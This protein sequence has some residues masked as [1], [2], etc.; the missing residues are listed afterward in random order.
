MLALLK[1]TLLGEM[2][3]R[4]N[5]GLEVL[6]RLWTIFS[7]PFSWSLQILSHR[8]LKK[9]LRL[10]SLTYTRCSGAIMKNGMIKPM[11]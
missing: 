8:N 10:N 6:Q 1:Q 11:S 4:L 2:S 7:F 3:L 9:V 5:V